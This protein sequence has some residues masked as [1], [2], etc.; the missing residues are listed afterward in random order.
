MTRPT[1]TK[2][3]NSFTFFTAY[4]D[5]T[6]DPNNRIV[7]PAHYVKQGL[8]EECYIVEGR[9]GQYRY[10]SIFT[11]DTFSSYCERFLSRGDGTEEQF[12]DH[13]R[14]FFAGVKHQNLNATKPRITIDDGM[15]EYLSIVKP[16]TV[17]A[18]VGVGDSLELW[19]LD[20]YNA[21]RRSDHARAG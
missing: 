5:V 18:I 21:W 14:S 10:L 4:F 13:K 7:I 19:R 12:R 15:R 20:D 16:E 8:K 3:D 11:S 2:S 17:M 9:S 6:I 1:E